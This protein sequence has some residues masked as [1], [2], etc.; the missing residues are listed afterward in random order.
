[1]S[2]TTRACQSVVMQHTGSF[3]FGR[4]AGELQKRLV[5]M[6]DEFD[7]FR[8]VTAMIRSRTLTVKGLM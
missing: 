5:L 8:A 1:M 6:A 2:G 7:R 4:S 3:Y